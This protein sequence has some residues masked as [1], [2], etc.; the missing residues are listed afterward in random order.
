MASLTKKLKQA[1]KLRKEERNCTIKRLAKESQKRK[2]VHK[3][4]LSTWNIREAPVMDLIGIE[5]KRS[6]RET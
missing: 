5:R 2:K 6:S 1:K 3:R 4:S